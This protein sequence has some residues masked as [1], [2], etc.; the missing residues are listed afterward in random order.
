MGTE[1]PI[2]NNNKNK[3]HK[4]QAQPTLD[5]YRFKIKPNKSNDSLKRLQTERQRKYQ[6]TTVERA[7]PE[8]ALDNY[9]NTIHTNKQPEVCRIHFQNTNSINPTRE[10]E[11]MLEMANTCHK[12]DIDIISMAE[13]NINWQFGN[14]RRL[15]MQRIRRFWK[16]ATLVTSSIAS[17]NG[18][19]QRGGVAMIITGKWATRIC[20]TNSDQQYG[21]WCSATIRGRDNEKITFITA[22]NPCSTNKGPSTTWTQQHLKMTADGIENPNPR[23][24]FKRRMTEYISSLQDEGHHVVLS[25]DAN[26][27]PQLQDGELFAALESQNVEDIFKIKYQ[28]E[29]PP[30]HLR[31]SKKIDYI[32]TT[33][34]VAQHVTACGMEPFWYHTDSDHR[35]IFMDINMKTLI[36]ETPSTTLP[37][38]CREMDSKN[39]SITKKF[40]EHT[41][42]HLKATRTE[43]KMKHLLENIEN[44]N[45]QQI[46]DALNKIDDQ[47]TRAMLSA[48]QKTGKT[49]RPP[50]SP[51]LLQARAKVRYWRIRLTMVKHKITLTEAIKKAQQE[52]QMQEHET[53]APDSALLHQLRQAKKEY[54]QRLRNA[55]LLRHAHLELQAQAYAELNNT[56]ASKR[57]RFLIHMESRNDIFK[58]LSAARNDFSTSGLDSIITTNED[59]NEEI[60]TDPTK[61]EQLITERNKQHFAQSKNTPFA[62]SPLAQL[63]GW[64]GDTAFTRALLDGTADLT[65]L[66][67][68]EA[69]TTFLKA[70][71]STGQEPEISETITVQD[72]A[73][74][75]Q[76][77]NEKTTTSPSGRHLGLYKAILAYNPTPVDTSETYFPNEPSHTQR[78]MKLITQVINVAI[79]TQTPLHRWETVINVMIEKIKGR[80]LI[81]KLR[82][83]HIFEADLNLLLGI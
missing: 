50:W 54:R 66:N 22:Y 24:E 71:K 20:Q 68:S 49:N 79:N 69:T 34:H 21:Q 36:K 6:Q 35:S 75:F 12:K 81:N 55:E 39:P 67:L 42:Q 18:P 48:E 2:T 58:K 15:V 70:L 53:I 29:P 1:S 25:M 17:K 64:H 52:A 27:H 14:S 57:L 11:E 41:I 38:N 9:G 46:E 43:E 60:I 26:T 78:I 4:N 63:C 44:L 61:I 10:F 7:L 83:I 31:G 76:L 51:A 37:A 8:G 13:T 32:M 62:T 45:P 5:Q 80:P 65:T 77:W 59:G 28:R 30:T 33:R 16:R 23:K 73:T 19:Y 40:R 82:I 3:K 47:I 56:V 74:G 72:I